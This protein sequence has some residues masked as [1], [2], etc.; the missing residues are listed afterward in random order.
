[1][2]ISYLILLI[3]FVI[4]IRVL[5]NHD[6]GQTENVLVFKKKDEK[7]MKKTVI[8]LDLTLKKHINIKTSKKATVFDCLSY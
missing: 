1:M 4:K 3:Q 5:A 7:I 2:P 6:I 8:L